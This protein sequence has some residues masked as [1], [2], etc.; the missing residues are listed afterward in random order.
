MTC[1]LRM[2]R[3]RVMLPDNNWI[4]INDWT[5]DLSGKLGDDTDA[6]GWE[7]QADFETFTRT[8]R[9]YHRGDSCR[10]RRWMCTRIVRPPRLDD[11]LRQL[12]FVLES[13]RD[14]NGNY[15]IL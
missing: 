15:N 12:K 3:E 14:E 10:R 9:G 5:V 2:A 4:W 6:V 11:P 13:V 8:R 1:T 7:Y